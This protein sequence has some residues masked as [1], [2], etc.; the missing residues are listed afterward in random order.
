MFP[1]T[2]GVPFQISL[3]FTTFLSVGLTP[4]E[5]IFFNDSPYSLDLDQIFVY[6]SNQQLLNGYSLA[7]ASGTMYSAFGQVPEPSGWILLGTVFVLVTGLRRH[8]SASAMRRIFTRE[9]PQ[10]ANPI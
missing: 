2:A 6:D 8:R 10:R 4:G 9:N 7:S 3:G 5:S 1:F